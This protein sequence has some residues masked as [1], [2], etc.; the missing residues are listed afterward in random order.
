VTTSIIDQVVLQSLDQIE[1]MTDEQAAEFFAAQAREL[2]PTG[3]RKQKREKLLLLQQ[4]DRELNSPEKL[5]AQGW[6]KWLKTVGPHTFTGSFSPFHAH[7]W[8]WYWEVTKKRKAKEPLTNDELVFLAFWARSFGKCLDAET[9]VQLSD[10]SCLAIKDIPIG[11]SILSLNET[12]G[13]LE[14]D[15]IVRKWHSG[16][17]PCIEVRTRTSDSLTLTREHKVL[18]FDGWKLAGE[19]KAGDRIA[20]PRKLTCT[21]TQVDKTDEE[22]KL[23][24]YMLA[25]GCCV[26][27][28]NGKGSIGTKASFTNADSVI[29]AD[30]KQCAESLGFRYRVGTGYNHYLAKGVLPWLRVNGLAGKKSIHKRCPEWVFRL[31]ERQKWLFLAAMIDTDGYIARAEGLGIT[32]ASE[33][34][35]DDLRQLFLHVGVVTV[36]YVKPNKFAGAWVLRVDRE[37][38]SMCAAL[39]PLI[40]KK[41]RLLDWISAN[42]NHRSYID[43]YPTHVWLD[44]PFRLN[45]KM[46]RAGVGNPSGGYGATREKIRRA[47]QVEPLPRWTWLENAQVFWN[48]V[49][50]VSD[51]GLRETYDVEVERNHNLLTHNLVTHNSSNLEWAAIAEGALVGEGYVLYV[52][53]TQALAEAHVSSIRDRIESEAIARYYPKL[54]EPLLGKHGNQW[55]WRQDFL[56]TK[57]GWSVRPIGL[58]VG[59]RGGKVGDMRPTMILFDDV[60]DHKDSPHVVEQKEQTIARAILPTGTRNTIVLF[61]QNLIHRNSVANRVKNRTSGLLNRRIATDVIPAFNDLQVEFKQTEHGPRHMIVGGKPTWPDMDL[62]AV[63]KFLDD[64]GLE[65][66]MAEYQ[67]DFS[68]FEQGRVIP[69]YDEHHVIRWS[70]FKSIF[71]VD[72][73]PEHWRIELGHDVGFTTGHI[74]A[75]TWIATSA[76]NSKLPSKRFRYRG[77]TFVGA[78]VDDMASQVVAGMYRKGHRSLNDKGEIAQ[79]G[80]Q[81]MSHEAKSERLT[82]NTKYGFNFYACDSKKTAG[83]A[84]WRHYLRYDHAIPYPFP[85]RAQDELLPD[86]T[87]KIGCPA[88]FDVVA[89][90]QLEIPQD[91]RGL[92]THRRQTTDWKWRPTPLTD[93][94]MVKDEPVKADEDANDSTRMITADWGPTVTPLTYEEEVAAA[95]PVKYR[96]ETMIASGPITAEREM[97]LNFQRA[98]AQQKTQKSQIVSFDEFDNA[99]GQ[100]EFIDAY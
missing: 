49:L 3:T 89:D 33:G 74:S 53:G 61:G 48:E 35:I 29:A 37:C 4:I 43:T 73:I 69:E 70:D 82:Y 39:M 54:A 97:S 75:W 78:S 47:I 68:A 23:L 5:E 85:E 92:K 91:D 45:R 32:L 2:L 17:K 46:R 100:E 52:S 58:D 26:E 31:P 83:I 86:K 15:K 99:I 94:G 40:L 87:W 9:P 50:T 20:S 6:E 51:V 44:L 42:P 93:S 84:Q 63:Q 67:H 41:Q 19:L 71:D 8:L 27:H 64:S 77:K 21:P 66:F 59:I 36:R 90:D 7:L 13:Q 57:S 30:F 60:D 11:S 62:E 81:K 18:T 79:L 95:I 16:L 55:G 65:A 12:S 28:P 80:K 1:G 76:M 10:G 38:M 34:L 96:Y 98:I 72:F 22:V 14:Q 25:E 24:A 56:R 88:W